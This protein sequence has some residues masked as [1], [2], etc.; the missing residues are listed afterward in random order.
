MRAQ[1]RSVVIVRDARQSVVSGEDLL[2]SRADRACRK[3]FIQSKSRVRLRQAGRLSVGV[4]PGTIDHFEDQL[5]GRS[6]RGHG[7]CSWLGLPPMIV[8]L[9]VCAIEGN[10]LA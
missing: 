5:F 6:H 3:A 10:I 7:R 2:G 9:A 1:H 4:H 8:G